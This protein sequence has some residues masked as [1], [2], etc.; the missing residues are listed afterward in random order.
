[1]TS[2]LAPIDN[3]AEDITVFTVVITELEVGNIQRHIFAAHFVERA[4]HAA[5]EY[6]PEAFDGLS[7]D[8]ADDILPS[9]MVND[10]VRIFAVKTLVAGPLISTKQADL[11]RHGFAN[12]CRERTGSYVRDHPRDYVSL[13]TDGADDWRFAGA[14]NAGAAT[15]AAFIPMPI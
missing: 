5:L 11:V 3:L 13:A 14:D 2:F 7:V 6:R 1:M 8:C 10:A 4:D 12:E 9:G 15:A